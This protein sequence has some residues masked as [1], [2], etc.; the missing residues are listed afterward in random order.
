MV[1]GM[2]LIFLR[3]NDIRDDDSSTTDVNTSNTILGGKE[4]KLPFHKVNYPDCSFGNML[5]LAVNQ[6]IRRQSIQNTQGIIMQ[7][8]L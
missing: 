3:N 8:N 1:C 6:I 5:G 7:N 4:I 2:W